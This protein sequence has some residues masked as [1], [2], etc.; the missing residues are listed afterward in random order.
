MPIGRRL[1]VF[2]AL[3]AGVFACDEAPLQPDPLTDCAILGVIAPT[4]LAAGESRR[5]SAFLEHC[6]PMYFPLDSGQVN[7]QSL[8]PGVASISGD[9]LTA[10]ARG[11][12]VIQGT[13][14]DMTQQALV[15]VDASMAQ[16]GQG[17]PAR[18]RVYGCPSMSVSQRGAFGAFAIMTDG[19]IGSV[20]SAAVWRSSDPSVAG[21]T[22]VTGA[23]GDRA[24]D[25][26]APGTATV[27]ATYQGLSA[28]IPVLV[29]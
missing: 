24:V 17:A 22:G 21:L 20:S 12:A 13:Y 15:M 5:L 8:D 1:I 18:V 29:H 2:L 16:P 11:A 6:R 4:T 27:T 9:T 28:T 25:A 14:G 19:S 7:W 23:A 26:F 3:A 10:V